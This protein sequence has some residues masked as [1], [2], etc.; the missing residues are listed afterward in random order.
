LLEAGYEH[1]EIDA[2]TLNEQME[3]HSWF[4]SLKIWYAQY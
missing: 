1:P 4:G 2:R 3:R